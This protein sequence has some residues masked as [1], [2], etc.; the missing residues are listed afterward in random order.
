MAEKC[1]EIPSQNDDNIAISYALRM[2]S[3]GVYH[4]ISMLSNNGDVLRWGLGSKAWVAAMMGSI[5][6]GVP[7]NGWFTKGNPIN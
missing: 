1:H 5:N 3:E 7:Q 6:G 4:G 2:E